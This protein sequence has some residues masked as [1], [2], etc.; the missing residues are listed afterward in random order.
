MHTQSLQ[1]DFPAIPPDSFEMSSTLLGCSCLSRCLSPIIAYLDRIVLSN[2]P[3]DE[4]KQNTSKRYSSSQEALT[5]KSSRGSC[6]APAIHNSTRQ[7][8]SSCQRHPLGFIATQGLSK[9][10]PRPTTISRAR[11]QDKCLPPTPQRPSSSQSPSIA[12][13]IPVGMSTNTTD[14]A[15][16]PPTGHI[17]TAPAMNALYTTMT[18]A[19]CQDSPRK[20]AQPL[21]A[22]LLTQEPISQNIY[23]SSPLPSLPHFLFMCCFVCLRKRR[24]RPL[25]ITGQARKHPQHPRNCPSPESRSQKYRASS[26]GSR[27]TIRWR[28]CLSSRRSLGSRLT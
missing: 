23:L 17:T 11:S 3:V 24:Q 27:W 7:I 2:C 9:A 22:K 10:I 21:H 15:T 18:A 6:S 12:L 20:I 1:N 8:S 26:R 14:P 4:T 25:T 28:N 16:I 13:T 5:W 19:L